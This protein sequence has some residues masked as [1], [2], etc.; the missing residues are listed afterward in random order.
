MSL[1]IKRRL[2]CAL[3]LAFSVADKCQKIVRKSRGKRQKKALLWKKRRKV[4]KVVDEE[5][6]KVGPSWERRDARQ[7]P[8][9]SCPTLWA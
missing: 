2:P 1:E 5:Q 6:N 3:V 8:G 4:G 9:S 7:L